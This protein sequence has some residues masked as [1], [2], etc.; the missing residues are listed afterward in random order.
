MMRTVIPK[1][2]LDHLGG[3][4]IY[5]C[6]YF[7]QNPESIR[8]RAIEDAKYLLAINFS[9][10]EDYPQPQTSNACKSF[11]NKTKGNV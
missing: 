6:T 2:V 1:V 11:I 3:S 10:Y 8:I 4:E 7:R 9:G 5:A